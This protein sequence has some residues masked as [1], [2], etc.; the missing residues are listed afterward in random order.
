MD[1][2]REWTGREVW[3]R[4]LL[5]PAHTLPTAAAPVVVAVGLAIHDGVFAPVPALV[6]LLAGW[7]IQLG[8]ALT[9]TYRN[10]LEEPEDR[11]HAV[12]AGAVKSGTLR[13]STLKAAIWAC[14]LG[15]ATA[16]VY[17][18][19]VAGIGRRDLRRAGDCRGLG[20][21]GRAVSLRQGWDRR[22]VVFVFFGIVAVLGTYYVQAAPAHAPDPMW[23]VVLEALP[24]TVV[25]ASLPVGALAT[26]L[27]VI[28]DMRDRKFDAV[29]GKRTVAVRFGIAWSRTEFVALTGFAYLCLFWCWLGL[30]FSAWVLL[31]LATLPLAWPTARAVLTKDGYQDLSP[32]KR[33][34]AR[35]MLSFS[36]LLATGTA[37]S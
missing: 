23:Q 37:V 3:T 6:A 35:L 20:L 34:T 22:P 29:K 10:L 21:F 16:C 7:L 15:A 28:D 33:Q 9:G 8:G 30:G 27:L 5:Y 12:L 31:P 25:A 24:W 17:L 36:L 2:A 18:V 1:Q 14:F 32:A 13:L 4:K 19:A 26:G 11:E